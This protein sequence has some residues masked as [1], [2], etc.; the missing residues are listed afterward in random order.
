MAA[1][2]SLPYAFIPAL[3]FGLLWVFSGKKKAKNPNLPPGPPGW[4]VVGNLL[5]FARTGKIFTQYVGDL[6]R[7]YGPI[8]TLQMGVRKMIIVASPELAHQALIETGPLFASRPTESPTRSLFTCNK[9]T[10]NSAEYGPV[11]R[12][13]RRNIVYNMLSSARVREFRP[14]REMVLDRL[15]GRMRAEVG[16]GGAGEVGVLGNVRF[17]VFSI[18]LVMCFGLE[19]DEE[20]VVNVDVLMKK[21]LVAINPR[22]DDYLPLLAPLFIKQ[23]KEAMEVR[24]EQLKMLIPLVQKRRAEINDQVG[25]RDRIC[26][27]DTLFGLKIDGRDKPPTDEELVTLCSEFINGGTDT[28]ATAVE[29]AF[30]RLIE[31]QDV[32]AKLYGDIMLVTGGRKVAELDLDK[33]VYLKAFTKELLRKHPPTHFLLPHKTVEP[34]KLGGYDIPTNSQVEFYVPAVSEDPRQWSEPDKFCPDRFMNGEDADITGVSEIKM[35]PF[36][37]G[38]RICPGLGLGT[39]HISLIVARMVQEFEWSLPSSQNPL[40]FDEKLEFTV[41]R[42][43]PLVA[44]I[45]PRTTPPNA[46]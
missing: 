31:N 26:Y 5:Q 34:T 15:I 18:L 12:A 16:N 40:S 33:I 23:R 30:V 44:F 9:F 20:T 11:W 36:G 6:R 39:V 32:Q 38:R 45:R 28:T 19:M 27:L 29:W 42:K 43:K 4:P 37:A 8:F 35:L 22:L 17:A 10:V 25:S 13:L 7:A 46:N 21:M 14:L 1:Y 41:M 24:E 2:S 3:L